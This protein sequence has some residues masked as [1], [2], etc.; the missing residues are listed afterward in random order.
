M[1]NLSTFSWMSPKSS[2]H[3]RWD[4]RPRRAFGEADLCR[5]LYMHDLRC[6]QGSS[7]L[8]IESLGATQQFE[9]LSHSRHFPEI[10]DVSAMLGELYTRGFFRRDWGRMR[11]VCLF[12]NSKQTIFL[13]PHRSVQ[14]AFDRRNKEFVEACIASTMTG[15][16]VPARSFD[17][18]RLWRWQF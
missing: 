7:K 3:M 6:C 17:R 16:R 5:V 9:I 1:A 12:D 11:F 14:P 4:S 18:H 13:K 2:G 15:M 10:Y 8:A